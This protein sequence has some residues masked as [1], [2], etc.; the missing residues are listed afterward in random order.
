MPKLLHHKVPN[1]KKVFRVLMR[2]YLA[3]MSG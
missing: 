1:H 2:T 3:E